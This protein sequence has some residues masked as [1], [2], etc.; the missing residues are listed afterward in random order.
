MT[1]GEMISEFRLQRQDAKAP[2]F[3]SDDEITSYVN[4]AVNEACERALLIEDRSSSA[5]SITLSA[6]KANYQ[7][8]ASV[9]KVERVSYAGE[10]IPETSVEKLDET[11]S[12]WE[13]RTGAP[14][15]YMLMGTTGISVT[16]IP[17]AE[18]ILVTNK[19]LLTVYRTPLA[20]LTGEGS[21]PE[22][23]NIHHLRL[24]YWVYKLAL[25]KNDADTL[26]KVK[27]DEYE[28]MFERAFGIRPDANVR[29]KH[30]DKRPSYIRV[31]M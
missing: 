15:Q 17:T 10:A 22:I 9:I 12:K 24:L 2:Y 5:T 27:A 19:L 1:L 14:T 16:P 3:W 30:R 28:A 23:P 7:L 13:V 26:N 4:A 6:G 8:H 21:S 20:A 11:I 18:T 31:A 29:R 25:L